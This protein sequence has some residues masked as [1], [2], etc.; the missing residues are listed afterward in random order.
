MKA[1][2]RLEPL[3]W[4]LFGAGAMVAAMLFPALYFALAFGFPLGWFGSEGESFERMR[5]LFDNAFAKVVVAGVISVVFWHAAH[6]LRHF[7]Y[8]MGLHP[9]AAAVTATVYGLALAGTIA[10]F[11]VLL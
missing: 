9:M 7:A 5:T 1:M 11:A 8:D 10:A 6:H 2:T 3:V 4:L